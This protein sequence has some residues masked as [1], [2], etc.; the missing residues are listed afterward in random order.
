MRIPRAVTPELIRA[1]HSDDAEE[2]LAAADQIIL[3][4][5]STQ[6]DVIEHFMT[7][8]PRGLTD[9]QLTEQFSLDGSST[10][11]SRRAELT[12]L[13]LVVDSGRRRYR[14]QNR[15]GQRLSE[16]IWVLRRW[17]KDAQDVQQ[18]TGQ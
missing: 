3:H 6:A 8:G 2:S 11:R 15:A 10:Y 9:R 16:T 18:E 5:T 4:L 1:A 7:V 12:A 17:Y 14:P 13:G